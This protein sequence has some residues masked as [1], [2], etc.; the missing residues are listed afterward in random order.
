LPEL[1][2]L[3]SVKPPD[4][5]A[6]VHDAYY[7]Y[8]H[9]TGVEAA[10]E[11][12]DAN[13]TLEHFRRHGIEVKPF[14]FD[15][16]YSRHPFPKGPR[17]RQQ[18]ASYLNYHFLRWKSRLMR[19]RYGMAYPLVGGYSDIIV[20]PASIVRRFCHY[21][22]VYAALD[23]FVEVAIPT[24]LCQTAERIVTEKDTRLKGKAMW[25]KS[26]FEIIKPYHQDLQQLIDSFPA[27]CLYLHPIKLSQWKTAA[28]KP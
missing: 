11:L 3:H 5:W 13:D 23:L 18:W 27:D 14:E 4:Y 21:C 19:R 24:A 12:P 22:G 8:L 9:K 28:A 17:W 15:Q 1:K 2:E 7:F 25:S 6:R 26:D 16:I 20:I 10:R